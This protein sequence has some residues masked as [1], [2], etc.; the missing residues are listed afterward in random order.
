MKKKLNSFK[1]FVED[2]QNPIIGTTLIVLSTIVVAQTTVLL[3]QDKTLR[4]HDCSDN[5]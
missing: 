5:N 2:H 3:A 4:E 1:T